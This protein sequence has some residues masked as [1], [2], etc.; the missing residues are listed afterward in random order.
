MRIGLPTEGALRDA[1]RTLCLLLAVLVLAGCPTG[2]DDD[3]VQ[4]FEG[5]D[6]GE[7]SDDADNDQDGL[8]DCD[9]PDC[10]GA[11]ACD[12]VDD[13]DSGPDDDDAGPN[14]DDVGPNDDDAGPD[15]DDVGPD[16]DDTSGGGDTSSRLCA[17]A[18]R[19]V[20]GAYTLVSCTGPLE[21]APG[22]ASNGTH[23]VTYGAARLLEQ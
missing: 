3:A 18:G 22:T 10:A 13:D 1:P 11:D 17:G 2:D 16:D 6:P 19:A 5:D 9:D 20:G 4:D 23:T 15:D 7:C 8:F 21:L 12:G 14:D